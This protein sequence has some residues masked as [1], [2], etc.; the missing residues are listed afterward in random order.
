M[1]KLAKPA[2]AGSALVCANLPVLSWMIVLLFI[3]GRPTSA[4]AQVMLMADAIETPDS[5]QPG[6]KAFILPTQSGDINEA[7]DDFKRYSKRAV[8]EKAFKA[9]DKVTANTTKGL[10]D[11]GD[12]VMVP[13]SSLVRRAL[14]AACS[15]ATRRSAT[16]RRCCALP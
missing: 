8:W 3:A 15:I 16:L 1:W 13:S 2:I 10:V 14:A 11:R 6:R 4:T 9:L 5:D 7:L 12:G